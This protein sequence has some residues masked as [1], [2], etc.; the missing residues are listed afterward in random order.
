[1]LQFIGAV[2][3]AVPTLMMARKLNSVWRDPLAGDNSSWVRYGVGIFVME[4]IIL[5]SGVGMAAAMGANAAS[6]F[7]PVLGLGAL[8]TLFALAIG[9]G[10]KTPGLTVNFIMLMAG[11]AVSASLFLRDADIKLLVVHS[12]VGMALYVLCV[13]VGFVL[14]ERGMKE[15]VVRPFLGDCGSGEWIDHPHMAV[16]GGAVYFALLG[17][18]ELLVFTWIKV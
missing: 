15:A 17:L 4:F 3:A 13:F 6:P 10:F 2:A 5:H 14:P 16:G 18:A 7:L 9:F 12:G 8:Y 1:M 11:R